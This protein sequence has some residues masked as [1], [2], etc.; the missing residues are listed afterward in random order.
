[1]WVIK[2]CKAQA[3]IVPVKI[4]IPKFAGWQVYQTLNPRSHY[5]NNTRIDKCEFVDWLFIFL[6]K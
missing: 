2:S 6:T 5:L 1:M 4:F 3:A